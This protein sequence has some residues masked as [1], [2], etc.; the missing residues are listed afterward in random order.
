M[1]RKEKIEVNTTPIVD[2][3]TTA[4]QGPSPVIPSQCAHWRGNPTMW[5]VLPDFVGSPHQF[6]DWFAMTDLEAGATVVFFA[7]V[8]DSATNL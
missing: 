5:Q 8:G 2:E 7:V 1:G 4:A 6:A 3:K